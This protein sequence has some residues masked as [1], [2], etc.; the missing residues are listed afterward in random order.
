[1]SELQIIPLKNNLLLDFRQ[2]EVRTKVIARLHELG[3]TNQQ[4]KMDNELLTL[5]CNLV[6]HLVAKKDNIS[7]KDLVI[8]ILQEIFQL[9][10]EDKTTLGNNIQFLW[11]NSMIKKVSFY[12]LFKTGIKEYFRKKV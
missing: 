4:Y 1:M 9:S 5:V 10:D 3:L 7:K 11:S 2:N 6:E 12:K 8:N